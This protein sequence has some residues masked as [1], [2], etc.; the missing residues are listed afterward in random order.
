MVHLRNRL[1]GA[2]REIGPDWFLSLDSDVL[3]HPRLVS[4]LIETSVGWDAVGGKLYMTSHQSDTNEV[5][6][7]DFCRSGSNRWFRQNTI[8]VHRIDVVMACV[9]M[10]SRAYNVDYEFHHAG[11]DIG[12][13]L[14]MKRAG[15]T[16]AADGRVT[17]RH[18]MSP[19]ALD[20]PDKRCGWPEEWAALA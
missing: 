15:V 4:N 18:V 17:N 20:R 6:F 5:S 10:R 16:V 7:A 1:L 2:V 11:E 12:H 14:A 9:L 19:E 13:A 8:G 3:V